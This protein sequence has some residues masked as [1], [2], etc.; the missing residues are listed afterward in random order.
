VENLPDIA[1]Q[2]QVT[3]IAANNKTLDECAEWFYNAFYSDPSIRSKYEFKIRPCPLAV[4]EKLLQLPSV[5][6]TNVIRRYADRSQ[7]AD[8]VEVSVSR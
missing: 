7:I 5:G 6:S 8:G 1:F 3:D 2:I 4:K